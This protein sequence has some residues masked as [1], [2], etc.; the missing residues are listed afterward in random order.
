MT[1]NSQ[2]VR[3]KL[4]ESNGFTLIEL[5]VVIIILGILS[6]IVIVSVGG[7]KNSA[8]DKSCKA[9]AVNLQQAMDQYFLDPNNGGNFP[10]PATGTT[11]TA[12]DIATLKTDLVPNYLHQLP[13]IGN[14]G[15]SSDPS[16]PSSPQGYWLQLTYSPV[17][18]TQSAPSVSIVGTKDQAGTLPLDA[19]KTNYCTVA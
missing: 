3:K 5:L 9:D 6:G 18:A 10:A 11:Y 8:V 1:L 12:A 19:P 7:A 14:S 15:G 2:N 17:S 16:N 13:P 4:K